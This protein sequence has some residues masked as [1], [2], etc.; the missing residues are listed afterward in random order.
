MLFR[1]V[2]C[3]VCHTR[4]ATRAMT[5]IGKILTAPCQLLDRHWP[6]SLNTLIPLLTLGPGSPGGTEGDRPGTGRISH[7]PE[8]VP[9]VPTS[10]LHCHQSRLS[11]QRCWERTVTWLPGPGDHS[12]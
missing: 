9:H 1:Q 2:A 12:A 3:V 4:A 11:H 5:H 8:A 6:S 7:M 10:S